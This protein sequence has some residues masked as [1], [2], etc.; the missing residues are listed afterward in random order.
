MAFGLELFKDRAVAQY[1]PT[2]INIAWSSLDFK[3][4]AP[5]TFIKIEKVNPTHH[6]VV[7]GIDGKNAFLS[8]INNDGII[9]F[10]LLSTSKTNKV[11]LQIYT[12]FVNSTDLLNTWGDAITITD[13]NIKIT[14]HSSFAFFYR[15]PEVSYSERSGVTSWQLYCDNIRVR[16]DAVAG[17]HLS[18]EQI[19]IKKVEETIQSVGK[20][21]SGI[22]S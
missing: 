16:K 7:T 13:H 20:T 21:I 11:L 18:T 5:E 12:E 4:F 15:A 9:T 10:S 19:L 3:G 17:E 1:D 6:Q 22:F 2:R 14:W 8:N